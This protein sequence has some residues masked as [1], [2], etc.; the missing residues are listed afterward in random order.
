MNKKELRQAHYFPKALDQAVNE[1]FGKQTKCTTELSFLSHNYVTTF[2]TPKTKGWT[3]QSLSAKK[4][5]IQAFIDG[6]SAG[7][8]ELRERL[9]DPKKWI[10]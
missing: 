8:I 7:N 5:E 6:W 2:Q 9:A 4:K 1:R 10:G 3:P